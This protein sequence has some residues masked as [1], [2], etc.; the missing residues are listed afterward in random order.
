MITYVATKNGVSNI[1]G[2]PLDGSPVKQITNFKSDHIFRFA[3]SPDGKALVCERGFF[4]NDVVLLS[5]FLP[6]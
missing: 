5:D 3:W 1:W 4:V 2:Q 6:S